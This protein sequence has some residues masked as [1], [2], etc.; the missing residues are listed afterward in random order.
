[1]TKWQHIMASIQVQTQKGFSKSKVFIGLL[2]SVALSL[3]IGACKG[4]PSET[5]SPANN[6]AN[7]ANPDAP[8]PGIAY[9]SPPAYGMERYFGFFAGSMDSVGT[10]NAPDAGPG[11][12][13]PDYIPELSQVSNI[14]H[15]DSGNLEAKL[16]EC[17]Q[18]NVKAIVSVSR[19]FFDGNFALLPEATYRQNFDQIV[20]II[21]RHRATV[22]AF[23]G[24]DE[25]YTNGM[26]K[27]QSESEVKLNQ[28]TMGAYVKS[29][30]ND[31]PLAVIFAVPEVEQ[32]RPLFNN[33]DWFGVDC[34]NRNMVTSEGVSVLSL[35]QTLKDEKDK[36]S[37]IDHKP[38]Y[39]I[40]VPNVGFPSSQ[41]MGGGT[42]GVLA[43][44]P[45][46]QN[47]I[48]D[49]MD[50]DTIMVMPFLWQ[51]F[52]NGRDNWIGAREVP[53][54]V[55]MVKTFYINFIANSFPK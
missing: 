35:I 42:K 10:G 15:I 46:Y 6:T 27:G 9:V 7:G 4:T 31:V 41:G 28:E 44:M 11:K 13:N 43:D 47:I 26:S 1:M 29:W 21:Q 48:R 23:Y 50:A 39:L 18:Y 22:V 32:H 33:F 16:V 51:S 52:D 30:F 8:E 14:I 17:E 37:N 40:S 25:A 45:V 38:R 34:Y 2:G 49:Q 54:I 55:D 3:C 5:P 12:P 20:P 53:A 36:L 24:L 19:Y